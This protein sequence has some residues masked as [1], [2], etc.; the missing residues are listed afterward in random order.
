[1][2]LTT[3]DEELCKILEPNV[4]TT[5]RRFEVLQILK[6][7]GIP[8]VV[9]ICPILPFIN[10]TREN[11]E[12]LLN[13]CIQ[14]EVYGIINFGIGVTLRD[15]DK[16]YFYDALDRHFPGMK[17]RYHQKYGYAYEVPSDNHAELME[18]LETTCR[19]HGIESDRDKIFQYLHEFPEGKNYEQL[20][21]F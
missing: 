5:K 6:E 10:D 14:A 8:T 12:G 18:L 15:G 19:T 3:Y 21:L 16:E 7:N 4:C 13:Y 20:T 9:W 2:T 11:M 1:M 17:G